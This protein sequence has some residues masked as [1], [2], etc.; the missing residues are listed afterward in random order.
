MSE[1]ASRIFWGGRILT[2]REDLPEVEALAVRGN[3]IIWTGER[4]EATRFMTRDTEVADLV[5]KTLIPGVV[6][7]HN[8]MRHG[9][10][11]DEVDCSASAVSSIE[12]IKEALKLKADTREARV[13]LKGRGYD[14]TKLAEERHPT[15]WD[16]DEVLPD[17]PAILVRTCGHISVVNSK[18]LQAVGLSESS[19]D[20][21]GGSMDRRNGQLTGVMR[22]MAQQPFVRAAGRHTR[23]EWKEAHKATA[24]YYHSF[25][26]TSSH[27]LSGDDPEMIA[28]FIE[29]RNRGELGLRVYFTVRERGMV[30]VGRSALAAGLITGLGDPWLRLGG[31]KITMDGS[32]GGATAAVREPYLVEPHL[33]I[34][35]LDQEELDHLVEEVHRAGFQLSVHA[36]GDRAIDMTLLAVERA[37]KKAPRPGHRHRIEHAGIMDETLLERMASLEMVAAPQPPFIYYLGESY[38]RN[39]GMDRLRYAY[40]FRSYGAYGIPAC[41]GSDYPV[42]DINPLVGL[43]SATTRTTEKGTVLWPEETVSIYQALRGYTYWG[44][45]ASFEEDIKGTLERGKLADLAVL[46]EDIVTLPPAGLLQVRVETTYLDGVPVYTRQESP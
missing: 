15:R 19:P 3:R 36:L 16:L 44:A 17:H 24:D 35:Y 26:I 21:Q 37:L 32:G 1:E 13:W 4:Q 23:A 10:M 27:E 45:Y 38:V 22:E 8:H 30:Q 11:G 25:G 7:S 46:S 6:E 29:A 9:V 43:Y 34:A 18:A 20:P 5:G 41:Y 33:G 14:H 42:V 12:D 39:L 28:A 40:P 31:Y 2:A